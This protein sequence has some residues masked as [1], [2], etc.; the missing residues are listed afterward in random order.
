MLLGRIPI[1]QD[2]RVVK[3]TM[4]AESAS[5]SRAL[6]R[7]LYARLVLESLLFGEPEFT[8]GWR[9]RMKIPGVVVTDAKSLYDHL[10]T[11]G[12]IPAERQTLIDL[13]IARDLCENGVL[14]I[15]WVPTAHQLADVLTKMMK[16]PETMSQFLT[17]QEYCLVQT[18]VQQKKEEHLNHLRQGQR[19]RRK[20]R[21][22]KLKGEQIHPNE[23]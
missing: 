16:V 15:C 7:Q 23:A 17:K 1:N 19:E 2:Y 3:S 5:L 11:T 8:E 14:E 10:R 18:E 4:A 6:D 21:M 9:H 12:S 13:L 20:S 22:K